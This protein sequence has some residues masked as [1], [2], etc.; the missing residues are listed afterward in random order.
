MLE[1][2]VESEKYLSSERLF[3]IISTDSGVST[4]VTIAS[5]FVRPQANFFAIAAES[6]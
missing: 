6:R 2:S 4:L 3:I 5:D 1:A